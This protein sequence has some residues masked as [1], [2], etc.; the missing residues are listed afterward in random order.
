MMRLLGVCTNSSNSE[1]SVKLWVMVLRAEETV[2]D[3]FKAKL[4]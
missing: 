2:G 3:V 4:T 1:V